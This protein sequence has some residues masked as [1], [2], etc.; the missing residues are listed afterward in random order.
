MVVSAIALIGYN[1][2]LSQNELKAVVNKVR[3]ICAVIGFG[4]LT[5]PHG[6]CGVVYA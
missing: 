4:F 6:W 1:C 2:F 3:L 5:A